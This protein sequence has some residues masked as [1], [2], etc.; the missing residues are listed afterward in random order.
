MW[1][2]GEHPA[3]PKG[4]ERPIEISVPA[5]TL[6]DELRQCGLAAARPIKIDTEGAEQQVLQGATGH[7][8]DRKIPFIVAELHEFGLA[9]LG[10]SQ[11]SLR[12]LMEGLGYSTF[13]LYYST[14]IPKFIPPGS[15]IRSPFIVNLLF[16]TP[17]RIAEY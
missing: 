4:R 8:A 5:T 11:Q 12:G 17:E 6:D 9:K 7:L 2:L 10:N 16:S 13:G 1:N 15:Q 3:N 14:S